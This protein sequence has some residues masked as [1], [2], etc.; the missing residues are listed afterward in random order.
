MS[1]PAFAVDQKVWFLPVLTRRVACRVY[2]YNRETG[3][4]SL[5]VTALGHP[6]YKIGERIVTSANWVRAR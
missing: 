2:Y 1:A 4:Y 5:Y 3:R 6:T